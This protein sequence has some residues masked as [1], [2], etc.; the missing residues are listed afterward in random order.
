MDWAEFAAAAPDFAVAGKRLLLRE[1]DIAIGFLAT[2]SRTLHL[3]PVC[4]IFCAGAIY[5]SVGATTPKRRDLDDDGRYVLHALL[6]PSD[7][8]FRLSG[9]VQRIDAA[10]ARARVHASIRFIFGRDDPIY[11]LDIRRAMWGFWE[12]AGKPG[13]RPVRRHWRQTN[14]RISSR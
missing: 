1:S 14:G 4:P 12:N 5:L 7:E 3:A 10:A 9:R 8:E 2:V 13:T 11:R 6:G